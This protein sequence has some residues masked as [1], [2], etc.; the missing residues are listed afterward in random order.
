MREHAGPAGAEC[1]ACHAP[2][3]P[4]VGATDPAARE[5]VTCEVC[6]SLREVAPR[7]AGAGFAL[8]L[9]RTKYGP[10]CDAKDHYFHRMGCSPLHTSAELCAACHHYFR[11]LPAGGELPVLTEYA[12]WSEGPYQ[13][14]PCQSCHMPG[15][16]A[17]VADGAGERPDV[18]H[19][20]WLG[21]RGDLRHRALTATA[22]LAVV[23]AEL[24]VVVHVVNSGAGHPVPTGLPERRIVV[25]ATARTPAGAPHA[26]VERELGRVLVDATGQPAPF[27]AAT[28]V[29]ADDRIAPKQA[30]DIALALA[31]APGGSLAL[32][33]A[34][35]PIAAPVRARVPLPAAADLPL[36]AATVA[37]PPARPGR[38]LGVPRALRLERVRP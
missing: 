3:A 34:W 37:V 8:A 36:L 14:R 31:L 18:A 12:D 19:H 17:E 11:P 29:A 23:G 22:T 27:Y 10:L 38:P 15:A 1:A 33:V 2:L 24:R 5:G 13:A 21:A 6:H 26:T 7:R 30:R 4:H 16:R 35:R 20:G 28:R 9:G 32:E 25:R